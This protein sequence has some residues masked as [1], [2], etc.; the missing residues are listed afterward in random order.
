MVTLRV[1]DCGVTDNER[2]DYA[3]V[4]MRNE[5]TMAMGVLALALGGTMAMSAVPA[6]A[7]SA[8]VI[9][10]GACSASSDWKIKAKPEHGRIEVEAEVDS[11]VNGQ[12]WSWQLAHNGERL[13]TRRQD[14]RRH[15]AARSTFAACVVNASG[16]DQIGFRAKNH[17]TG[18]VCKGSLTF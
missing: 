16:A 10:Q 7:S 9:K 1:G 5:K 17:K 18:E 11:N 15:R 6:L 13:G 12:R 8:D 2:L 3:E 4:A 14:D